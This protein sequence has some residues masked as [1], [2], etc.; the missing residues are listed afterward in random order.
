MEKAKGEVI[1]EDS[2]GEKFRAEGRETR[3]AATLEMLPKEAGEHVTGIV[4]DSRMGKLYE[5]LHEL[6]SRIPTFIGPTREP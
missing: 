1:A 6:K 5:L 3:L 4:R 2:R